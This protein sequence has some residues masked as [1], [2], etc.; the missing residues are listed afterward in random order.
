MSTLVSYDPAD[1]SP[2]GEVPICPVEEIPRIIARARAA[3]PGW[4]ALGTEGRRAL[5]AP[6]AARMIEAAPEVGALIRR[7]MGK[8]LAEGTGEVKNCGATLAHELDEIVAALADEVV[9][10]RYTR[11]VL[12]YAPLGVCAAITPWNFPFSMPHW[13][14]LPALMAGNTVVF[15]PSE[16]TPLTGQ[17]Y[18]E[19]LGAD[20]PE[21]VL[22][23]VHGADA[24]GR[25]LVDAEVD[26][27][28]FTGS[29]AVGRQ[30][31]AKAAGTLKRVLLELG[32]KDPLIVLPDADLDAAARFAAQSSFRNAGQVCVSTERIYVRD[33]MADAFVDALV[34]ETDAIEVGPMVNER[35]RRHVIAQMA[36]AEAAGA[37]RRR[38]GEPSAEG[39]YLSP[40]V[41]DRVTHEM[42]IAQEETFGPVACVI[43][44]KDEEE[45]I[46][47]ANDSPYGLGAIV[48][49]EESHA[50][51]VGRRLVAGMIGINRGVGGAAGTPWVGARQSG[52]GYH[53]GPA[54]HRQFTQVRVLSRKL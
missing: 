50:E 28:A 1:G 45:A 8:P 15:K 30:I 13:M 26:L 34:R 22:Q 51:A 39:A 3:Q 12:S 21:G 31:L 41:F 10:D 38:G 32:G 5:I 2:V 49:G 35:Q 46:R 43:R 37:V 16:E 25:A 29:R 42:E 27:I 44:V 6:A 11:S 23:V 36:A 24:Q 47:L 33:D 48:F 52:Y 40:A 20:L 17:R 7:E 54:G 18:A 19:L 14:V 53:K 4:A 9:A